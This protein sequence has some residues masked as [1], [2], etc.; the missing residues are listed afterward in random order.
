VGPG[1]GT[2]TGQ[3]TIPPES[4]K[5]QRRIWPWV[6]LLAVLILAGAGVAAYLLTRPHPVA[7]PGVVDDQ[8]START[9]ILNAGFGINVLSQQDSKPAGIVIFQ[10]PDGGAKADKGSTVTVTV[11]TGPG[12]GTVPSVQGLKLD[13]AER[14]IR[15]SKLKVGRVIQQSSAV[16]QTG[17]VI[18]TSPMAG[19]ALPVGTPVVITV[20][21]G[22]PLIAIPNVS[23]E[24]ESNAKAALQRAGFT[25][26]NTSKQISTTVKPGDVIAMTPAPGAKVTAATPIGLVIAQA[27]PTA[28]VPNVVGDT[29]T[30]ATNA[31]KAAGFKVAETTQTVTHAARN[32]I[33]ISQSPRAN[34]MATKNST[35]TIVVGH[36]KA[37]PPTTTTSTTTPTTTTTTNPT[38]T[39]TTTHQ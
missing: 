38:T 2:G 22:P 36:Y 16:V 39:T 37:P 34:R 24:S 4:Q 29:P 31:L 26:I 32:G 10:S 13:V 19:T 15:A 20:S 3:T 18:D 30:A 12:N 8:I 5:R 6:V 7:V 35:V 17:Q 23:G 1:D 11:S 9:V 28:A 33:V 14:S 27:P 21:T 25:N